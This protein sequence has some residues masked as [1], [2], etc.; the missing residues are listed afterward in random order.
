M[1]RD[2]PPPVICSTTTTTHTQH[3]QIHRFQTGDRD[4]FGA[5]LIFAYELDQ[6]PQVIRSIESQS[7]NCAHTTCVN[8][9][10]CVPIHRYTD[11]STLSSYVAYPFIVSFTI[12]FINPF[13]IPCFPSRYF[14]NYLIRG[15]AILIEIR[16]FSI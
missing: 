4:P 1:W 9:V 6:L 12:I 2:S 11:T 5:R 13:P 14:F 3:T 8:C 15:L 16:G 7:Q 10:Y